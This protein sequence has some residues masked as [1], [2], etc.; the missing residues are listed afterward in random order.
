[1]RS[2][3]LRREGW[4]VP[5]GWEKTLGVF[6]AVS[7]R[8]LGDMKD[9]LNFERRVRTLGFESPGWVGGQQV[10]GRRVR[11]VTG[12]RAVDWAATDGLLTGRTGFAL[13]VFTADCVPVFLV[14][15]IRK[16]FGLVHAGWRGVQNG[17]VGVAMAGIARRCRAR[18]KDLY[19]T[20]GPHIQSCC[21]A[22]GSD[23]AGLFKGIPGAVVPGKGTF[24]GRPMLNLA[25]MI[26]AQVVRAGGLTSRVTTAPWCTVCDPHFFSYRREQTDRRQVALLRAKDELT[27]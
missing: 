5:R 12:P 24:R 11:F 22:V 27:E 20:M 6:A 9:P 3:W 21:C 25:G 18:P 8:S 7:T 26:R 10:H 19:V 16:V 17:I 23:V 1:M 13:R 2:A 15:P 4:V 14:D